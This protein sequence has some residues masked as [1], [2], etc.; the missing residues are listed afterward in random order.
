MRKEQFFYL[1][2]KV[3]RSENGKP[4][5]SILDIGLWSHDQTTMSVFLPAK[6][7]SGICP[8]Q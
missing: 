1:D 7:F 5:Q 3:L 6:L 2:N 4:I 8:R